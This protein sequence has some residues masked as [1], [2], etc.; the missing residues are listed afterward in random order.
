MES[1]LII[2]VPSNGDWSLVRTNPVIVSHNHPELG[3]INFIGSISADGEKGIT[4]SQTI[5][6]V[7]TL[8]FKKG[9][10]VGFKPI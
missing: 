4:G 5:P 3:D 2:C 10:L 8:T 1:G 6:G 9:L 7:G